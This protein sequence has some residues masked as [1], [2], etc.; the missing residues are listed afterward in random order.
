MFVKSGHHVG[1]RAKG[2]DDALGEGDPK[3][4]GRGTKEGRNIRNIQHARQGESHKE[5]NL[6]Q[7]RTYNFLVFW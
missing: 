5:T 4:T 6:Y 7:A 3:D 2:A 1:G